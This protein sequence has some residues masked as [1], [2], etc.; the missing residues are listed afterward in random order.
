ML[1][2][3]SLETQFEFLFLFLFKDLFKDLLDSVWVWVWVWVSLFSFAFALLYPLWFY[4]WSNF[5]RFC[6]FKTSLMLN[7]ELEAEWFECMYILFPKVWSGF[8][9]FN[10][11][12][13]SCFSTCI[14]LAPTLSVN[15]S[16]A[17]SEICSLSYLFRFRWS[18]FLS[19]SM[20][21][22]D[23]TWV[24]SCLYSFVVDSNDLWL[25]LLI[26]ECEQ[27]MLLMSYL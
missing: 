27:V 3:I 1:L 6:V 4:N 13:W 24:P 12:L 14:A 5:N 22:V 15:T 8:Y 9:V 7:V 26:C 2:C 23:L 19:S 25:S 17:L 20:F 21:E 10:S 18:A 11:S 16:S